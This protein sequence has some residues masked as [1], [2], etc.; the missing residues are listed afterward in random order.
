MNGYNEN[1]KQRGNKSYNWELLYNNSKNRKNR[2][3]FIK[4]KINNYS[5]ISF[6]N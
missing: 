2:K 3:N 5:L 6:T 1:Y 4:V